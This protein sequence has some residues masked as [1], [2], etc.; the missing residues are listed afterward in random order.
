[1]NSIR[2]HTVWLVFKVPLCIKLERQTQ[3]S[4]ISNGFEAYEPNYTGH[5]RGDPPLL[6]SCLSCLCT[7]SS[8][9][10]FLSDEWILPSSMAAGFIPPPPI[11]KMKIRPTDTCCA[12]VWRRM[13]NLFRAHHFCLCWVKILSAAT[14][15]VLGNWKTGHACHHGRRRLG[16]DMPPNIR[17]CCLFPQSGGFQLFC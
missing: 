10:L 7:N 1:M 15:S 6:L 8:Y 13:S 9:P 3:F 4:E 5:I 14:S 12:L 2:G 16:A 17:K 11:R